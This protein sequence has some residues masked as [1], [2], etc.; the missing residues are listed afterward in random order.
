MPVTE[1]AGHPAG[2]ALIDGTGAELARFREVQSE[3][4]LL[5]DLFTLSA[6]VAPQ[7]AVAAVLAD[8]SGWRIGAR[9][10]FGRLLVAAGGRPGRHGHLM[11]RDLVRDPAPRDWLEP[12]LPAGVRLIAADRQAIELAPACSAAYPPDHPDFLHA[13]MDERPE[14]ELE[15]IMSGRLLGPLLRCSAVAVGEDGAV[16]GAVLVNGRPGEPPTG[17]PWI[18]QL[19]RHPKARGTGSALLRRAL[20]LATRDGFPAVGLVVTHGNPALGV[21]EAHGFVEVLEWL[22]VEI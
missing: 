22:S 2:R 1:A 14:I 9:E 16:L 7:D 17:G 20:A 19:F 3:E 12:P 6:G 11:S 10:P 4:G 21:Y 5:A 18:A 15:A 8:L 13:P